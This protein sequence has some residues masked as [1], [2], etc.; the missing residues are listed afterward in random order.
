MKTSI[1][2][3][4][5]SIGIFLL[6]GCSKNK[7]KPMTESSKQLPA[8]YLTPPA[9]TDEYLFGVGDGNTLEEARKSALENMISQ[10]GITIASSYESTLNVH[11]DYREYFTKKTL[12]NIKSEIT[13]LRISNYETLQSEKRAYNNY[14]MLIRSN[15]KQFIK[16][17][18][19]ELNQIVNKIETQR[20][21]I[22]RSNVLSRYQFYHKA[23]D[24]LNDM[25]SMLLVLNTLDSTFQDESYM[26]TIATINAELQALKE[27]ITFSLVSDVDSLGF[28]EEIN[29]ALTDKKMRIINESHSDINHV[30]IALYATV[31]YALSHGF[32]IARVALVIEVK[33]YQGKIIGGN[34][35]NLT[36]YAT[37]GKAVALENAS[38]KFRELI[39]KDGVGHV[40]GIKV[41]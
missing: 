21:L 30:V 26:Q 17:L 6:G 36:G 23:S 16:S 2:S 10:L 31:N 29:V 4:L 38:R 1:V 13:S 25:F 12:H 39:D 24:E 41:F 33:D 19:K 5:I 14:M 8:W 9:M 37:Q 15:K 35:M 3:L 27:Q 34:R 20:R 22:R 11:K 7:P 18:I 28:Q 40:L 32:D